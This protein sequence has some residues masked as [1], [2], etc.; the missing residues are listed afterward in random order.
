MEKVYWILVKAF[1]EN[2]IFFLQSSEYFLL[3]VPF[4]TEEEQFI[5]TVVVCIANTPKNYFSFVSSLL[6]FS[7]CLFFTMI[8]ESVRKK[9]LQLSICL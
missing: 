3:F 6:M 8:N 4:Q 7:F 5:C 9:I 2:G 1:N